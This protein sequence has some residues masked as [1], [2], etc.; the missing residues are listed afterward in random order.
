M[1]DPFRQGRIAL[2]EAL[3]EA[4]QGAALHAFEQRRERCGL[5]T[6]VMMQA[7]Q[8]SRYDVFAPAS[9]EVWTRAARLGEAGIIVANYDVVGGRLAPYHVRLHLMSLAAMEHADGAVLV[10]RRPSLE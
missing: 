3:D 10:I 8:Q 2:G 1:P 9:G 4:D 7:G 6:G 5:G